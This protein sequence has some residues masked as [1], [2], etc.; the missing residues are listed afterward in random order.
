MVIVT[1][2][3]SMMKGIVYIQLFAALIHCTK[4]WASLRYATIRRQAISRS[5]RLQSSKSENI[6]LEVL[7]KEL[8][9]YLEKRKELSADELAKE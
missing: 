8:S 4:G 9:E 1:Y 2:Y 6:D 7:K 3:H 5:F